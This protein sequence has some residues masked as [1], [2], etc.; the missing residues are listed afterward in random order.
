MEGRVSQ[1]PAVPRLYAAPS[2]RVDGLG[3][4]LVR[5][6]TTPGARPAIYFRRQAYIALPLEKCAIAS[7]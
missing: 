2:V 5:T 1:P 7:R 4:S 3:Y 6:S